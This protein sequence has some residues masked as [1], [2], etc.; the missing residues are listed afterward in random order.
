M[1]SLDQDQSQVLKI[2]QFLII[3]VSL[4][5][6]QLHTHTHRQAF[7]NMS[8]T[9]SLLKTELKHSDQLF[10]CYGCRIKRETIV[11][12]WSKEVNH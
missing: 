2:I 9:S 6:L 5:V 12:F 11:N 8:M 7:S 1:T 4:H 10:M 3:R